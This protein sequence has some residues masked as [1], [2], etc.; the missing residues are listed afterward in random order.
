MIKER[1]KESRRNSG[2]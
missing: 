2:N 1:L